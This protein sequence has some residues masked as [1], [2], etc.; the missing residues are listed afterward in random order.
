MHNVTMVDGDSPWNRRHG[1]G[2]FTGPLFPFG[3]I[4]DYLPKPEAVKGLPKFD[5]RASPGILVGYYLQPGGQW[6]GE[7]Q[8][9]PKDKFEDFD[10]E[11]P[12]NLKELIPLRTQEV[13]LTDDVPQYM[14]KA[15]YDG[16]RRT[17][18]SPFHAQP[19]PGSD[20]IDPGAN[21]ADASA[22]SDPAEAAVD[23]EDDEDA[24]RRHP[25][26]SEFRHDSKGRR[27]AYDAFGS[28][29]MPKG[30][31]KSGRPNT[32]PP[33]V[34]R[35]MS[36]EEKRAT[37]AAYHAEQAAKSAASAPVRA[38]GLRGRD[39]AYSRMSPQ[40]A[41][42]QLLMMYACIN[43][44]TASSYNQDLFM[45][46]WFEGQVRISSTTMLQS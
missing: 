13:K 31:T 45:K 42:A 10:W 41:M 27:Y 3:C 34:W 12:R 17:L 23:D 30:I 28:R 5:T 44:A 46:G 14:M 9:F 4:V 7:F 36:A 6:K 24:L 11:R 2:R 26:F 35:H 38:P 19:A 25:L 16:V 43:A 15:G 21:T 18:K 37:T 1:K 33:M 8:V 32:C 20:E 40:A 39:A 22:G 29:I